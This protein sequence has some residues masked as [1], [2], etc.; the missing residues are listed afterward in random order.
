MSLDLP[1]PLPDC[2]PFPALPVETDRLVLR[3][4]SMGDIDAVHAYQ[5]LDSVTEH[6]PYA[7]RDRVAAEEK[8]KEVVEI[9]ALGLDTEPMV[10]AVIEKESGQLIG[11]VM[12]FLRDCGARQGE[13][14]YVFHPDFHGK[15]YASEAV[16]AVIDLGFEAFGFHRIY[17]RC[18]AANTGSAK[19]MQR[20]GMRLEAHFKEHA[21]FKGAWDELQIFAIL[22]D[23]WRRQRKGA[24]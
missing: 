21:L 22:E 12:L 9:D 5:S 10:L 8:L 6:L 1:T 4:L 17:G 2:L 15:G 18:S 16:A 13:V 14:G 24:A 7:S 23:E 20:M 11:E 19:L 3:R